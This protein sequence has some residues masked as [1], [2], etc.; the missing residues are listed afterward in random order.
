MSSPVGSDCSD[1]TGR[2]LFLLTGTSVPLTSPFSAVL[3]RLRFFE[4][5]LLGL[6]DASLSPVYQCSVIWPR[7]TIISN[8]GW[9]N[10]HRHRL[11]S[12]CPWEFGT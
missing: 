6:A 11:W 3:A 2:T 7:L 9:I 8:A 4:A 5:A 12:S 10:L 1:F